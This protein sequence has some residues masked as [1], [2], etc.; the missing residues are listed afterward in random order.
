[1]LCDMHACTCTKKSDSCLRVFMTL[2][3]NRSQLQ[4]RQYKSSSVHAK[5]CPL[6]HVYVS[7]KYQPYQR[8]SKPCSHN[9]TIWTMLTAQDEFG[10]LGLLG[11]CIITLS[12][13]RGCQRPSC[14]LE[15]LLHSY[16]RL[17]AALS[18]ETRLTPS[19]VP[20]CTM[21]LSFCALSKQLC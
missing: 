6:T 1:M 12:A 17:R 5:H 4:K 20:H 7:T 3:S 15:W 13:W 2:T 10:Y 16:I 14:K 11:Q 8:W 18:V 9:Q 21:L 19:T